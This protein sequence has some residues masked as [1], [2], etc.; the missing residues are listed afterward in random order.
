MKNL[1]SLIVVIL[2]FS[3]NGFSQDSS[4]KEDILSARKKE[5]R[6][7]VCAEMSLEDSIRD[8][9]CVNNYPTD[10]MTWGKGF[11]EGLAKISVNGKVGFINTKGEIVIQPKLKDAGYFSENLAPFESKNGKWGFINK[12]G[13]IVIKPRFGWALSFSEGLALVQVGEFWGY[14]DRLGKIVIEPKF[15]EASDF[16]EGYAVVG[17]YDKD[18]VWTT[19]KRAN[20]KWQRNFIDKNGQPKFS[21]SFDIISRNFDG[22]MAIVSRNIG[23][24]EKYNGVVSQTFIIDLN[25]NDLWELNSWFVSWFSDD[26]IV[27]AVSRDEKTKRDKY[28]FLD[29]N[30]NRVTE[31]SFDSLSGFSEGLSFARSE[32]R[33][34]FVD[35]TGNFVIESDFTWAMPFSEGLAGAEKQNEGYGFIDRS[36][37]WVINP[38]FE[39]IDSFE[40]GFAL[41]APKGDRNSREKTGY[42]DRTGKYIWKPTK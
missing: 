14:I 41:V 12:N 27:V 5:K 25:G 38:Q 19:H 22:G 32:G 40:D 20:G 6:R 16:E 30:G 28:S 24:S 1:I 4:Q 37:K 29:R 3:V 21:G 23:Y 36:G 17:Y 15:E 35:K 18:Y 2:L 39:W 10:I 8:N 7:K 13:E 33:S 42:I 34:G 31:K 26:V 9:N 11:S